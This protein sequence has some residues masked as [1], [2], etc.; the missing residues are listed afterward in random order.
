MMAGIT[1]AE[2]DRALDMNRDWL[3]AQP[4]V[5]AIARTEQDGQPY[6]WVGG[7]N[8]TEETK[9]LIRDRVQ[10]PVVFEETGVF[11]AYR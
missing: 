3:M 5:N 7:Q 11:R 4:G 1:E 9:R 8:L 2:V 6:V 10:L